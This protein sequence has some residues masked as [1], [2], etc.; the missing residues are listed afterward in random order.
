M[1]TAF[2]PGSARNAEPR[3]NRRW[4][5][6]VSALGLLLLLGTAAVAVVTMRPWEKRSGLPL[7]EFEI[8]LPVGILLPDDRNIQVMLWSGNAGTG[9]RVVEVRRAGERP[10]V[11]GNF[12]VNRDDQ[13]ARLSL[14]LSNMAEGFWTIPVDRKA[15]ALD[16]RFGTWQPIHFLP[17]PRMDDAPLPHGDYDVRYRVKRYL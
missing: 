4:L 9:C 2:S 7:V 5:V 3:H 17:Q 6:L 12:R 1:S 15:A 14:R 8:R 11:A 10:V 16:Q 13:D